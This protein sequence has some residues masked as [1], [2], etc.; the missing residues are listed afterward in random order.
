MEFNSVIF[1]LFFIVV[2]IGYFIMPKKFKWVFL[3]FSS[4][5]FYLYAS[6]KFLAFI[7]IT[8]ITSY[9]V[10]I[11]IGEKNK[12]EIELSNK[13]EID[14]SE[15]KK[16]K[17]LLKQKKKRA[18]I[19]L[20]ILNFGILLF[21]KYFNF[22]SDNL[23]TVLE[24]FS[25]ASRVPT[26]NLILPLGISFYTFQTMSYVIDV[27][28]GK[29]EAERN[30]GK[31]ALFVSFFPQIIEGPI[32]RFKDLAPQLFEERKCNIHDLKFGLQLMLWGFFKKMV[33]A[34]RVAVVADYVF[35]NYLN[36]SGFGTFIGIF[37][38]AIQDYTDFSG[39]IDI[40]RGCAKTMGIDMAENFRRP[41][42]SKTIPEF[43]R[44]WHMS[45]GAWMK[46]YVFYPFSLTKS[47]RSL[48]K[49][50]KKKWG[51]FLGRTLPVA[52]GNI[53]VFFLV[54][55][56][57]GASW[58]YIIWGLFY[59]LLIAVSA[60]LKP[61]FTA[62]IDKLHINAKSKAFMLFQIL[63]TFWITCIGCIIFRASDLVSAWQM[64]LKSFHAFSFS[65]TQ[66]SELLS[67]GLNKNNY[68]LL[69]VALLILF[70]IDIMQE[71]MCI[72]EWLE[73]KPLILRWSLCIGLFMFVVIFG[74]YGPGYNQSQFVYM[75][76]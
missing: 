21:L 18:L 8:T 75:Q 76:F 10:A 38:Y 5:F 59:G 46:D 57:H 55:V 52:I 13:K 64:I 24:S 53:L 65:P 29:V 56:W 28:W 58:N 15:R 6:V 66:A 54:G 25:V 31:V 35:E 20:L 37:L 44:R 69:I 26:F 27:Y 49:F 47:M 40:A 73:N 1:I 17:K 3:L 41:Y 14:I 19:L 67:F 45:L 34:D 51:K 23:N 42:F 2:L 71:K 39:A 50:A 16:Q 43:W 48:G 62:I 70:V 22:F 32:G 33:I 74:I 61:L 72:R 7:L 9:Y 30:L 36:I 68:I 12:I 63:R 4:Y 60:L 11:Y